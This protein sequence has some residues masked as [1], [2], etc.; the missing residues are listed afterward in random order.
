METVITRRGP[1]IVRDRWHRRF[2][3]SD[4][5]EVLDG[6]V[7]RLGDGGRGG[8]G[9]GGPAVGGGRDM[10]VCVDRDRDDR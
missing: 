7:S 2:P 4:A 6:A 5:A 9:D 10:A 1:S 3:V 8:V